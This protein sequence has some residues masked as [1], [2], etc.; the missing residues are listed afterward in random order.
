MMRKEIVEWEVDLRRHLPPSSLVRFVTPSAGLVQDQEGL[1]LL[2]TRA[3]GSAYVDAQLD[4]FHGRRPGAY[5]WRP[6]LRLE[7]RARFT[8]PA[9][10]FR[11]TA[12]F[13]FWN[14]PFATEQASPLAIR[15]PEALWFFLASPPSRLA[16]APRAGWRGQGWF[17]QAVSLTGSIGGLLGL[18]PAGLI[19]LVNFV[20]ALRWLA[21]RFA[22]RLASRVAEKPLQVCE[23]TWHDYRLDWRETQAYFWVDDE[24]VLVAPAPPPGPLAFVAWNDNQWAIIGPPAGYRGGLLSVPTEQALVLASLRL[25]RPAD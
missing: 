17:A 9:A 25:T 16:F 6:P 4:D 8:R 5:R 20:P 13:G 10:E 19:A 14:A 24:L 3:D 12:G 11:G 23:T 1:H 15:P 18:G 2:V 22:P 7:I 21:T